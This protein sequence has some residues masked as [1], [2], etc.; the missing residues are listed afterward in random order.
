[1]NPDQIKAVVEQSFP[2]VTFKARHN[3]DGWAF[4]VGSVRVARAIQG[5]SDAPTYFKLALSSRQGPERVLTVQTAAEVR[6][7]MESELALLS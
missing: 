3:P 4:Y 2:G 1:M 5:S 6:G 7:L